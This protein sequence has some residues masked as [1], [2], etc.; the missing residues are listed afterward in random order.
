MDQEQRERVHGALNCRLDDLARDFKGYARVEVQTSTEMD[1][2][3]AIMH[4]ELADMYLQAAR[5]LDHVKDILQRVER[6]EQAEHDS[7][8]RG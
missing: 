4:R 8:A 7:V 1:A 3:E 6:R 5:W 2:R